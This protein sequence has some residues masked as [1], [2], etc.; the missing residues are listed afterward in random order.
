ME[1]RSWTLLVLAALAILALVMAAIWWFAIRDTTSEPV[2]VPVTSTDTCGLP[3]ESGDLLMQTCEVVASDARVAG[4][5]LVTNSLPIVNL[6]AINMTYELKNDGGS[7]EGTV[8][9]T[10]NEADG[11]GT[12]EGVLQGSGDYEGL[13]YRFN[14]EAATGDSGAIVATTGTIESIPERDLSDRSGTR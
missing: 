6:D 1:R 10:L 7:W 4:T 2:S 3:I 13:R 8:T 9:G 14:G 11:S 12:V 5:A